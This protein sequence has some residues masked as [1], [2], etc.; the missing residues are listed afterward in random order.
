MYH[1]KTK[2]L[3][4]PKSKHSYL[5]LAKASQL[6][7]GKHHSYTAR[8]TPTL[9]KPDTKT[10]GFALRFLQNSHSKQ[11]G[12]QM[13]ATHFISYCAALWLFLNIYLEYELTYNILN[14]YIMYFMCSMMYYIFNINIFSFGGNSLEI[15]IY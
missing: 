15:A 12:T 6:H 13:L 1:I 8:S 4:L 11:N 9:I 2:T 10:V 7:R 5:P 3:P 14:T